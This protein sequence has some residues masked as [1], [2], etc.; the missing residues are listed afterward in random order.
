LTVC[1]PIY[2]SHRSDPA[3]ALA[4]SP[5]VDLKVLLAHQP[6]SIFAAAAAGYDLQI[7]GHTHGGQFD[8]LKTNYE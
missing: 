6:K 8:T 7:S 5:S 1:N 3:K 2:K 4:D